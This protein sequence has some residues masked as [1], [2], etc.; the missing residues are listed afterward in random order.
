M[1]AQCLCSSPES[2]DPVPCQVPQPPG[3]PDGHTSL[4]ASSLTPLSREVSFK[5][6]H[7]TDLVTSLRKLPSGF[8]LH[9][10]KPMPPPCWGLRLL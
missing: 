4:P 10:K 3:W 2:G 1:A 7:Q 5:G 8:L 6:V 9:L